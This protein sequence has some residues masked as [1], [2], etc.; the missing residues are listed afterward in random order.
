MWRRHS[1]YAARSEAERQRNLA[2]LGTRWQERP[3]T[4]QQRREARERAQWWDGFFWG[5][6]WGSWR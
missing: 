4:A 1:P 2:R 3:R 6:F 5:L